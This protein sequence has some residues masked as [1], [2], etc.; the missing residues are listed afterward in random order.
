MHQLGRVVLACSDKRPGEL[1]PTPQCPEPPFTR[2]KQ[3]VQNT[4]SAEAEISWK[5]LLSV[6]VVRTGITGRRRETSWEASSAVHMSCCDLKSNG[7]IQDLFLK[8]KSVELLR[9]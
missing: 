5:R 8:V 9:D 3:P 7:Q 4:G 2:E 1:L 6:A